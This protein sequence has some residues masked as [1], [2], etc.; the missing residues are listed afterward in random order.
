MVFRDA[1]AGR[2]KPLRLRFTELD[3]SGIDRR[4]HWTIGVAL[5][6]LVEKRTLETGV[7]SRSQGSVTDAEEKNQVETFYRRSR[8][9]R[10]LEENYGWKSPHRTMAHASWRHQDHLITRIQFYLPS[11]AAQTYK[12]FIRRIAHRDF[13]V[14]GDQGTCHYSRAHGV[15]AHAGN[16]RS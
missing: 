5:I 10:T 7:V 16:E 9:C 12:C 13:E 4:P 15:P 1:L 8:W 3:G 14:C 2:Q 11:C 6:A